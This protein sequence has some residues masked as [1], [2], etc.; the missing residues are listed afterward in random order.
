VPIGVAVGHRFPLEGKFA[1]TPFVHPR[2]SIDRVKVGSVSDTDTNI[3]IDIGGS[4]EITE[5][6]QVRLAATLG[7]GDAVGVSFVWLPRGLR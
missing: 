2:L 5:Q 3:D 6:M 7:N 4:F 1:I